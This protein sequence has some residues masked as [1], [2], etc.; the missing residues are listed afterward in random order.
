MRDTVEIEKAYLA[1]KLKINYIV[2]CVKVS[3]RMCVIVSMCILM[4]VCGLL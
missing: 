3:E 4:F 2:E 1:H